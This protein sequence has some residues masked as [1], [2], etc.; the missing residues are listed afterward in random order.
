VE[1]NPAKTAKPPWGHIKK[2]KAAV[3]FRKTLENAGGDD[4][5]IGKKKKGVRKYH[6]NL[7]GQGGDHQENGK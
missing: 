2:K 1:R 4:F 3:T 5:N 6:L 7:E